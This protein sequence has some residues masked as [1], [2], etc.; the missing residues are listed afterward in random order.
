V[1][2]G[3]AIAA[4]LVVDGVSESIALGLTAATS[5]ADLWSGNRSIHSLPWS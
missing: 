5:A 1:A 3:E 2:R 4:G